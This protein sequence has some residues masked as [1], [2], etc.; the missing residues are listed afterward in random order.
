[1]DAHHE[2]YLK[3]FTDDFCSALIS[4]VDQTH[5][6]LCFEKND[7]MD[8]SAHH[9]LLA[10]NKS[11]QFFDSEIFSHDADVV[12]PCDALMKIRSYI[13]SCNQSPLIV[14]GQSGSGKTFV[15]AR[16]FTDVV[17]FLESSADSDSVAC[18]R[19]LGTTARSSTIAD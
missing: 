5:E 6:R 4:S 17:K 13:E 10:L 9:L 19:F 3:R 1:M 2:A 14:T 18:I 16:A 12:G 11:R 15:M 7:V 8:E